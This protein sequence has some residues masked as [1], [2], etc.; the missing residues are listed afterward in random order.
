M[1]IEFLES[2]QV[3]DPTDGVPNKLNGKLERTG[4]TYRGREYDDEGNLIEKGEE[5]DLPDASA[6]H[7]IK[8]G[9]A[10]PVKSTASKK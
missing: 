7:F 10:A 8:R 5:V 9:I 4:K 6:N 3:K 1:K 2:Y